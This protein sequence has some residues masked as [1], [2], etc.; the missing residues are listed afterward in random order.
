ME[1]RQYDAGGANLSELDEVIRQQ[2]KGIPSRRLLGVLPVARV[3]PQD[4]H[5][6]M[7]YTGGATL[8]IGGLLADTAAG[9]AAGLAMGAA[10]IGASALTDY[11]L[12]LAKV[13]PIEAHEVLDYVAGASAIV[14]PFAFGY[15][16]RD[17]LVAAMHVAVGVTT[18]VASL[19][20]D[21][22]A[23]RGRGALRSPL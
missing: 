13:I 23:W 2:E 9:R 6:V 10:V 18:V 15:Y 16:R 17:P 7:D 4:L 5:S 3:I 20:T 19:L 22:R 11:R 12:S 14:A 8:A 1:M 21:Y